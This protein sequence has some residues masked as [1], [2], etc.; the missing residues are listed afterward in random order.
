[1]NRSEKVAVFSICVNLFLFFSKYIVSVF[2]GSIAIRAEAFHSLT[3]LVASF[4]VFIGLKLSK[5]KSRAF[6]YGLYKIENLI[7]MLIAF[8]IFYAAYEIVMDAIFR[9][10]IEISRAWFAII[11]LMAVGGIAYGFSRYELK[12]G[13]DTGSPSLIADAKHIGID[14]FAIGVVVLGLV[15]SLLGIN[16]DRYASFVIAGFICWA[17]WEI[18]VDALRVLLDA[19]LDYQTLSLAE[20]LIQSEPQVIRVLNLKGRNSGRYKFIEADIELKTSDFEKAYYVAEKIEKKIKGEIKNVDEVLIHYE[21][22]K[23]KELVYAI[24]VEDI[25]KYFISKHFGEAPFFLL[26]TV[27]TT[28][29]RVKGELILKNPF[30]DVEKKKGILVAEYL[31]KHRVDVVVTKESLEK[32]GPYYVFSDAAVELIV[33]EKES[34]GDLLK[35]LDI[36]LNPNKP[37]EN[38]SF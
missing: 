38:N 20:K 25:E 33:T 2:S 12:V 36:E 35:E 27:D 22:R 28:S 32:K 5:R 4:T 7:S 21:P 26:L 13:K 9:K 37:G 11:T 6:P 3:D 24:P 15:A 1:M 29:K 31:V 23:K 34:V 18:L 8:A 17:G 14:M 10:S 30:L 19:S 16:I